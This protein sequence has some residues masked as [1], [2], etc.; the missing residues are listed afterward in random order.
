MTIYTY[1][2]LI[3]HGLNGLMRFKPYPNLTKHPIDDLLKH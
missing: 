2:N 3:K 1:V